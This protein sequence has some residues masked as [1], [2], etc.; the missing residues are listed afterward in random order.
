MKYKS[1]NSPN[2]CVWDPEMN[3]P[4]VEFKDGEAELFGKREIEW[5]KT[6]GYKGIETVEKTIEKPKQLEDVVPVLDNEET[7]KKKGK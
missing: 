4:L 3:K 5:M 6:L 2:E 1:K 7:P